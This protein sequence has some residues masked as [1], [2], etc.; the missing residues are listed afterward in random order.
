MVSLHLDH[1]IVDWNSS[2]L[3]LL[4]R[5]VTEGLSTSGSEKEKIGVLY[6]RLTKNGWQID[7]WKIL[8]R[9]TPS[10]DVFPLTRAE[11]KAFLGLLRVRGLKPVGFFRS[12]NHFNALLTRDDDQ[13]GKKFFRSVP[14]LA[15]IFRPG[16][17][18]PTVASFFI[19]SSEV[20]VHKPVRG[21]ELQLEYQE[22]SIL[23][24]EPIEVPLP[25]FLQ[26][27]FLDDQPVPEEFE[28][29]SDTAWNWRKPLLV[30]MLLTA[31]I[32]PGIYFLVDQ[33]LQLEAEVRQNQVHISWN[34][35]VGILSQVR[36]G[37]LRVGE[38]IREL[39]VE[40]LRHGKTSAT[41][42]AGDF[43]IQLLLRGPYASRQ[44]AIVLLA[45]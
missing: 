45:Q 29:P 33:P 5:E 44:K 1:Q 4:R 2:S 19:V 37:E 36:G 13:F 27:S 23:P 28:E 39:K 26:E 17:Q 34:R 16:Y 42:P 32:L 7:R 18:R 3:E 24:P 9:E 10:S 25:A 22:I 41:L 40:E 12:K 38:S 31:L 35:F 8:D 6:G 11:E 43:R 20:E 14:H 21:V 15:V 30:L